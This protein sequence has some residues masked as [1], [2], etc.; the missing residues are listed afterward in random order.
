MSFN[1]ED[2]TNNSYGTWTV[3]SRGKPYLRSN[4]WNDGYYW[5]CVCD[6]G[7]KRSVLGKS[8]TG[9]RSKGCGCYKKDLQSNPN[10]KGHKG[11]SSSKFTQI[12]N[13]ASV[14]KIDFSINIEYAWELLVQQNFI[15]ALSGRTL[16]LTVGNGGSASLDRIDS[17]IGYIP[18][19]CQWIHK[20]V[21]LMKNAFGESYFIDTCKQIAEYRKHG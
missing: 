21:N 16:E 7:T 17:K 12:R 9:N 1:G 20:D 6:C 4:G 13:G 10:W 15:C 3:V 2:L 14:R 8:L 11:L 18:G 19:N 5:N